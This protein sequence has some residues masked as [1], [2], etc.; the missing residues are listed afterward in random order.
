MKTYASFY[1]IVE[2]VKQETGITNLVNKYNEIV[3][4]IVRAERDIN[5]FSGQFI[6]KTV[7]YT[8]PSK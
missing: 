5:P 7:K 2:G 3:K 1:D 4:L 8:L 6:K